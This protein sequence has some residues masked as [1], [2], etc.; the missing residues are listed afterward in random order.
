MTT[1][2][3]TP[4]PPTSL[5]VHG[6]EDLLAV[7]PVLIGFWLEQSVVLMTFGAR[8]PFHA[9]TD[10]PP[11]AVQSREVRRQVADDLLGPALRHGAT[12][13]VL[14]YYADDP[15]AAEALHRA[16]RREC[17]RAGL[18]VVA[19]LLADGTHYRELG[20]PDPAA[21]RRRHP[22]D[23]TAHP[24]VVEAM[25]SG[26]LVHGSRADLVA[27]LDQDP[28]AAAAVSSALVAG[29]FADAGVPT[30]GRSIRDAG[31]WVLGT[32]RDLLAAAA[33][34]DDADL[35][36]LLWVMQASRV[37]DAA[38]SDLGRRNA[39]AHVRLWSDVVRRA[40][41]AL[42]AAPAA[43]LGW[44]AWQSGNGA[45]AWIAVDRCLRACPSYR[46]AEHLGSILQGAVPPQAWEGHSD[47]AAGL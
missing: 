2:S 36:R 33:V 1:T 17:R 8:H 27:S 42:V 31:E 34:P 41:D 25:V 15:P 47:W 35:A 3:E 11:M 12:H 6:P 30:S 16:L 23:V 20:H 21:R 29:R 10:L 39:E 9:R 44:S 19:A 38:W 45:L 32:V 46:L 24:F 43:L 28:A 37:R 4:R 22:Y 14:L 18:V 7:A 26:R 5:T 40:P 13:A